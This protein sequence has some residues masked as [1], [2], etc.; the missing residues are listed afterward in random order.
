MA[1][2]EHKQQ[3]RTAQKKSHNGHVRELKSKAE[4]LL[5]DTIHEFKEKSEDVK[6]V[7]EEYVKQK[8]MKSIGI[9]LLTGVALSLF[10]RR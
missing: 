1:T 9:A 2:T 4:D 7:V 3:A 10:L 8:P 6:G 5:H